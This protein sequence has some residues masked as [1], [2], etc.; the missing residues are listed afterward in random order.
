[1]IRK[2]MKVIYSYMKVIDNDKLKNIFAA[3]EVSKVS[4]KYPDI[5]SYR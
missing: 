5:K 2:K 3:F 4:R 1:M